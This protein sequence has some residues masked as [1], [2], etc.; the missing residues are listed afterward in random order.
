MKISKLQAIGQAMINKV[1]AQR[2]NKN[3][4][5]SE[6]IAKF[7]DKMA[8]LS[9]KSPIDQNKDNQTAHNDS[10]AEILLDYDPASLGLDM[11]MLNEST[12]QAAEVQVENPEDKQ[13]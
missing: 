13:E 11:T 3:N 5:S 12:A 4:A 9:N 1:V 7:M 6:T 2:E 8:I 10:M